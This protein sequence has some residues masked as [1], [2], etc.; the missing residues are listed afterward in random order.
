MTTSKRRVIKINAI[1]QARLIALMLEGIY[2]CRELAEETGL[3]YV[4]VLQYTRELRRAG[5]AHIA[6]WEKDERGR[7][8]LKIYQIGQGR[9]ARRQRLTAAQRQARC[10][11]KKKLRALSDPFNLAGASTNRTEAHLE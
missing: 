9:D 11:A 5:A 1:S 6:R 8:N 7:D 2:T 10:R 3:H 4:T